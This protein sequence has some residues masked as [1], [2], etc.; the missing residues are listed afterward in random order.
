SPPAPPAP[1]PNLDLTLSPGSAAPALAQ[2][3]P[4][5]LDQTLQQPASTNATGPLSDAQAPDTR[6]VV[7]DGLQMAET[8]MPTDQLA[9]QPSR[10]GPRRAAVVEGYEVLGELG[11]GG[12]GVV[13]KAR[14]L[15]LNRVVALKMIRTGAQAGRE[16]L[17]RFKREAEAVARLQHP[18]IVQVF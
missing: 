11:R 18:N 13:Y 9:T 10:T 6:Y 4:A 1:L 7:P 16:E 3:P 12:M 5:A 2:T 8:L 14:H 15:K 17:L